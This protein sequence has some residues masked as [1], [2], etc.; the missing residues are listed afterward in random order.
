[1]PV[2]PVKAHLQD[3]AEPTGNLGHHAAVSA[4]CHAAGPAGPLRG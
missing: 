3:A 1:M 2:K 4:E